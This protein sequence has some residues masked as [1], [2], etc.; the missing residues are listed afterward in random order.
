MEATKFAQVYNYVLV[1]SINGKPMKAFAV[2][3]SKKRKGL[4][5]PKVEII[6]LEPGSYEITAHGKTYQTNPTTLTMELEAGKFYCLGAA[7]DGL[8][9]EERPY[10]WTL[11]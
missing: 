10:E 7:E 1:D 5:A 3:R 9:L 11:R 6:S 8:Y 2:E 4:L